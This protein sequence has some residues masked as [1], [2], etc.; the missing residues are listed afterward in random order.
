MSILEKLKGLFK[1]Q[2]HEHNCYCGGIEVTHPHNVGI[3][4]CL[5]IMVIPPE[6]LE[7]DRW[8]VDGQ[9]ITGYTLREQ[10][11]YRQHPCGCWSRHEGSENS[12]SA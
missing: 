2:E 1:R 12:I 7:D 11:G 8:Y 3:R 5:R 9:V 10:R 4:G 6:A